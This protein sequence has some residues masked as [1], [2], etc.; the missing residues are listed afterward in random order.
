MTKVTSPW[1]QA[2]LFNRAKLCVEF[3]NPLVKYK[4][5][6]AARKWIDDVQSVCPVYRSDSGIGPCCSVP[7]KNV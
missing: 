7:W 6:T 1:M 4:N 5:T 3:S 2:L